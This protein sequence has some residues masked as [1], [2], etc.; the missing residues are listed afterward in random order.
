MRRLQSFV[1]ASVLGLLGAA[2]M[3]SVAAGCSGGQIL[4]PPLPD[5]GTSSSAGGGESTS[6]S[7]G[8]NG[9]SGGSGGGPVLPTGLTAKVSSRRFLTADHMLAS[10]EMQISGEPFAELLG[11]KL[12]GYDRFSTK[13]DVY[14]DPATGVEMQDL[15]GF[16]TAVESYEYSKQSMNTLS[17]EAGAGLSLQFGPLLNPAGA[18]GDAAYAILGP[19]L[20]YFAKAS[21]ASGAKIGKDFVAVPPPANDLNNAYGWAGFWPVY[22]EFRS[23]DPTIK[24]KAGADQ[25]C[26]LAGAIDEPAPPGTTTQ[27]VGDYECDSTSLN[28]ADREAQVEKVIELDALGL[29]AWKQTLWTI[30]YWGSLHDVD[31]HPIVKV[32]AANMAQVGIPANT[33]IGQWPDPLDPSGMG[34]VYG[35]DGTFFGDVSLEGWQGLVMLEE[36]DNK[37]ALMLKGLTTTDGLKVTGVATVKDAID[38]DYTS[39]VRWWPGSIAVTEKAT[40]TAA[41]ARKFFPKATSFTI[42]DKSSRLQDLTAVLGGFGAVFAMTDAANPEVGGSQA[43]LATFDGVPFVADN[44]L[45]DGED[46][47]H[48][49]SLAILKMAL[50]NLDRL[51]FDAKHKVLTDTADPVAKTRGATVS[52]LHTSYSILGL[53]T[54]IRGLNASLTLYSNDTPD[55]IGQ[56]IPLDQTKLGGAPFSGTLGDRVLDLIKAQGDFLADKLLDAGGLAANGWDLATDKADPAPTTLEAQT[57]AIRGL[58]E[59]YLATSNEHYRQRAS[60]AYDALEKKFWMADVHLYRT[61]LGESSTMKYTPVAFGATH[62]A[63]RQ[64]WKLVANRPGQEKLAAEVLSRITSGMKIV[65]NGWNDANG[66]GIVQPT[67]CIGGGLQMAERALT[68]EFSIVT[69]KG[70]RDH[71]CVP[72]IATAGVPAA[73]AAELVIERK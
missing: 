42:Q 41:E 21:R 67:E 15:I 24:A 13:P 22:A 28:L 47:L 57:S 54:A 46:S 69:D 18:E 71:D 26:S 73:L 30:N 63:L 70:D 36:I 33:V 45:A 12:G 50:V 62:G 35:K 29:A 2:T 5:G 1:A 55:A 44:G 23:F 9:G 48:D 8:G 27:Y 58:L 49:R 17:F 65:V 34:L 68:G 25:L 51:H 53:R 40:G 6:S 37:S 61:T 60:E 52:T 11:R 38:Y 20:Q 4:P 31:Q 64:L 7:T 10:I 72:D 56:P 14:V 32:P 16:S 66:D 19:R 39:P 59:A 43:F 3:S